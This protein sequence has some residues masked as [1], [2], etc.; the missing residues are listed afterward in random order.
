MPRDDLYLI[1][2]DMLSMF[3]EYAKDSYKIS[4]GLGNLLFIFPG[5]YAV[6]EG[7]INSA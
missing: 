7:I 2:N 5:R 4:S 1:E 6:Y 3:F